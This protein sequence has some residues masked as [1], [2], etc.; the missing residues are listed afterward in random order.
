MLA[1]AR[2]VAVVWAVIAV[3]MAWLSGRQDRV[4]L[5]LQCAILLVA[6]GA[7]SGALETSLYALAGDPASGWPALA[8][9]QILVAGLAVACL[10]IPVAQQSLRWGTMAG[11]PQLIVLLLA[12]CMVGGQMV[13]IAAPW[14][15]DVPGPEADLGKLA[16]LRTAILA[17]SAVTLSLS[18]RHKRWPEARWLAY[19]VLLL[20]GAKLLL[21]DFP[22]GRPVTLF[23]AL[24]L[25]GGALILVS[26]LLSRREVQSADV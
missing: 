14:L 18:S 8:L 26:K 17:A 12:V 16:T 24:A 11:L 23:M 13:M 15:A 9:S 5:S 2:T 25:V 6:A 1:S 4:S 22:H 20:V 10:F 19:P 3:G 7:G 21:E